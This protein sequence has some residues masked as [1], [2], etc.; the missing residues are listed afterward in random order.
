M[1]GSGWL[2]PSGCVLT[3]FGVAALDGCQYDWLGITDSGG[4]EL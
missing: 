4:R 2:R 3:S 1:L